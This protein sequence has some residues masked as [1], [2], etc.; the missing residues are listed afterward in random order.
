M[1]LGDIEFV[2]SGR[3]DGAHKQGVGLLMNKV[4]PKSFLCC[5][6]TNNRMILARFVTKKC[7]VSVIVVYDSVELTDRDSSN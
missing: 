6:S 4:A 1:K 3:K 7:R 5:K 2:F